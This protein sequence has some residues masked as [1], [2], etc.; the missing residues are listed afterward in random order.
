MEMDD[1]ETLLAPENFAM[2]EP[3]VYRSAFPRTK[4]CKFLAK[5]N[6]SSV[7]PL[8]PEDYPE[9]MN[10][11][12][13]KNG[14]KLCPHGLEGN[15]W[16]FKQIDV[17]DF[18]LVVRFIL[19]PKNRPLLIHCNKGKHRTGCVV[20]CLRKVRGW[21]LSSI[22][23]E[24]LM[25]ADPKS[26]LEDQRFIEAFELEDSCSISASDENVEDSKIGDEGG[27]TIH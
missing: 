12:Y 13:T 19:D 3:G 25:F 6:L 24:Y 2:V 1:D 8:V 9:A 27:N 7:V 23:A 10:V 5:L 18:Q 20:A 15:K 22:F 4:H 21:S 14:T 26:R 16:P 11:F 17:R